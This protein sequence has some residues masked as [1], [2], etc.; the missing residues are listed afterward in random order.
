MRRLPLAAL[1]LMLAMTLASPGQAAPRPADPAVEAALRDAVRKTGRKTPLPARM[2]G[3]WIEAQDPSVQLV[4]SGGEIVSF[5]R[6]V[7]YDFKEVSQADGELTVTLGV[8]SDS[9]AFERENITG[10][11]LTPQGE[12]HAYNGEFAATYIRAR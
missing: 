12:L 3:R 9:Y 4:V 2:Q 10:L 8:D 5:G 11:M 7:D 6:I 1:S